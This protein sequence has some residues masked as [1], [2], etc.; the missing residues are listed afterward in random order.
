MRRRFP[1][2]N[3]VAATNPP[4]DSVD[5]KMKYSDKVSYCRRIGCRYRLNGSS[6]VRPE[7][8]GLIFMSLI[9]C[10]DS[11]GQTTQP[12]VAT[13]EA[14]TTLWKIQTAHSLYEIGLASDGIVVPLYYGPKDGPTN[15]LTDRLTV[16]AKIGSTMREI[17]FRGGLGE[18]LPAIEV[19][20]ADGVRDADLVYDSSS[21]AQ[22]EGRPG[23]QIN[24][25]DA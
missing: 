15:V 24:V 3:S 4:Q 23:L 12:I 19:V 21:I 20:Y 7:Q 22:I 2:A 9:A 18:Q 17:P 8:I 16:S 1:R 25:K 13:Q 5:E 11:F 14:G 6:L 10:M